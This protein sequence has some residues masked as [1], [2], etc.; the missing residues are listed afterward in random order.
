MVM[1]V[2]LAQTFMDGR[3]IA[4]SA[5]TGSISSTLLWLLKDLAFPTELA[6]GISNLDFR[7]PSVENTPNLF[8]A[9]VGVGVVVGFC[10]YPA[11][12][13]LV[14]FKHWIVLVLKSK[15]AKLSEQTKLYR[16]VA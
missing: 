6:S 9:G 3:P 13:I 5:A 14:L 16:V 2:F 10:L 4:L 15:L 8:L 7:C 11:V 1:R 12:E